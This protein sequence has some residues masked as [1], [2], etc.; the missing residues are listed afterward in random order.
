MQKPV[1][2]YSSSKSIKTDSQ[3]P[4]HILKTIKAY[5]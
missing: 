3:R 1:K 4:Y 5:L 2:V